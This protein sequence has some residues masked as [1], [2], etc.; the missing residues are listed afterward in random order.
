LTQSSRKVNSETIL[1]LDGGDIV[2]QY[3]E[4]FEHQA[5]VHDGSAKGQFGQGYWLNQVCG[6]NPSSQETFPLT[7]DIYSTFETGFKSANA[8]TLSMVSAVLDQVGENG[9]WVMDRGYDSGVFLNF[10]L[11][12]DLNFTVR[13]KVCR[14]LIHKGR[15][16]NIKVLSDRINRRYVYSETCRF[17]RSHAWLELNG[18]SYQVTLVCFK[19]KRNKEP[20]IML[21]NGWIKSIKELKRRIN[22]YFRRWGVE[23][24]YRFEKQGFGI[25]KCKLTRFKR[26]KTML[27][28]TLLSW[29]VL[30][31]INA[32]QKFR[33]EVL[34]HAKMEK[35]KAKDRPKFNYYRLLRAIKKIFAG[36]TE[37][38]RFRWKR[39]RKLKILKEISIQKHLFPDLISKAAGLEVS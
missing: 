21:N 28:M 24:G 17:G 27:G 3:G 39:K 9:L 31:K 13:M 10:F 18:K 22:G 12:R 6:Y 14:N 36:A 19:D 16:V 20:I 4:Q 29:L 7:L 23:E 32:Q 11:K 33:E 15:S 8:K 2:H 26:I 30:T 35:N 34:A 5:R 1:A 25:E 37:L 38:F